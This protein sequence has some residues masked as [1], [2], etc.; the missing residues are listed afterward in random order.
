MKQTRIFLCIALMLCLLC[1]LR[2]SRARGGAASVA[3]AGRDPIG[4]DP[5]ARAPAQRAD[6]GPERRAGAFPAPSAAATP[7][8]SPTAAPTPAEPTPAPTATAPAQPPTLSR[9]MEGLGRD[10]ATL[11]YDQL[12]LVLADGS[13]CRVYAYD[14]GEGGIWVKALGFSGFVGEK[15]VSSAKREGDKRTPAGIFRLGFAFGSEETPNPDYPFRAVTQESFWVDDP[16]SRFYNLWVEGEAERDW[17]SAERLANSPTA[18]ALAVRC[19]VQLR[20]GGGAGQGLGDLPA[21]GGRAHLRLHR[22]GEGG[23]DGAGAVAG[24]GR[25]P[26]HR[27]RAGRLG[28][29]LPA[30]GVGE[31]VLL[32]DAPAVPK[33][34]P[35]P[36]A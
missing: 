12:V 36:G 30:H 4:R 25:L 10:L 3:F 9:V 27:H 28:A 5:I 24:R 11:T 23:P 8:A 31:E 29:R 26:A 32:R 35:W 2:R 18:Y 34:A 22:A 21:R 6:R 14:K 20:P 1:G 17:S 19:G 15:G 16:D 33:A 7:A 13:A